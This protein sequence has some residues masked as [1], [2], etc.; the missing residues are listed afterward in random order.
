MVKL[1][2]DRGADP[3]ERSASSWATPTAWA[4]QMGH[5]DIAALLDERKRAE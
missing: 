1:L 2:L 3:I 4:E 5:V